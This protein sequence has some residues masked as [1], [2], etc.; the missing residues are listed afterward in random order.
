MNRIK[1]N[2]DRS[3]GNIYRRIYESGSMLADADGFRQ[4]V[5]DSVKRLKM[6]TFVIRGVTL[7]RDTAGR[8][9][10]AQPK[11]VTVNLI[12]RGKRST[13]ISLAPMNS[14]NFATK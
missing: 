7:H 9:V 8:M 3:I 12:W 11:N 6:G 1:V 5:L 13:A 10:L 4:D 2:V 14:L